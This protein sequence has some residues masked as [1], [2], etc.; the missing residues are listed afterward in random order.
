[1]CIQVYRKGN[2]MPSKSLE[3]VP[4]LHSPS[5]STTARSAPPWLP[6]DTRRVTRRHNGHG[7]ICGTDWEMEKA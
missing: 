7:Q 1:M 5:A 3:S 6:W 2:P 4:S